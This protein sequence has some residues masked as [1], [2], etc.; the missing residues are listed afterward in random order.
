MKSPL[1][2]TLAN[3]YIC[4]FENRW[5]DFKPVINR[6]SVDN[7]FARFSFP[8]HVNKFKEYLSS[9]HLNIHFSVEKEKD[10]FLPFL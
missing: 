10:N 7:I 8:D 1:G 2:Q 6:R 9:K 5:P 4:S 3:I